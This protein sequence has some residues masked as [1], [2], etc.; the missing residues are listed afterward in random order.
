MEVRGGALTCSLLFEM[1]GGVALR[2]A[3]PLR[4]GVSPQCLRTMRKWPARA[5]RTASRVRPTAHWRRPCSQWV[6]DGALRSGSRVSAG[7]GA[8]K[9][10]STKG[11]RAQG[12]TASAGSLCSPSKPTSTPAATLSMYPSPRTLALLGEALVSSVCQRLFSVLPTEC[13]VPYECVITYVRVR[14][15]ARVS[16]CM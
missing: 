9:W 11:R 4:E 12:A 7:P 3:C 2:C 16:V 8:Q 6:R 5:L 13:P 1:L 10:G 15:C 14:E